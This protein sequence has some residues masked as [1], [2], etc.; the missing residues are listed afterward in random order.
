MVNSSSFLPAKAMYQLK[1]HSYKFPWRKIQRRINKSS[2]TKFKSLHSET[3]LEHS[4]SKILSENTPS[5]KSLSSSS[6]CSKQL[7]TSMHS[8]KQL[9]R[10]FQWARISNQWQFPK[11]VLCL[12]INKL[13][14]KKLSFS[15]FWGTHD[16]EKSTYSK[17]SMNLYTWPAPKNRLTTFSIFSTFTRKI[18]CKRLT[19]LKHW[20]VKRTRKTS[21]NLAIIS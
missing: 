21:E 3:S 12:A 1:S 6:L 13:Y 16:P 5:V 2:R 19:A 4:D 11:S 17:E 20:E 14:S 10:A 9:S 7:K 18:T 8:N 15:T